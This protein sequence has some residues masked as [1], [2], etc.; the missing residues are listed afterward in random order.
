MNILSVFPQAKWCKN[1]WNSAWEGGG[2]GEGVG[3]VFCR[4]VRGWGVAGQT[5][6]GQNVGEQIEYSKQIL[7]FL[8]S[9]I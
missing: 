9:K 6:I 1:V 7:C 3:G 2:M 5:C 8:S 4:Q